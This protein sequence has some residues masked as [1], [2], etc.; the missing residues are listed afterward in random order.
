[1]PAQPPADE[2]EV[3]LYERHGPVAHVTMNRPRYRNARNSAMTYALDATFSRA[4]D[5]PETKADVLAGAGED[6]F[7]ADPVVRRGTPGVEMNIA[8]MKE[9]TG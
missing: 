5:A 2:A 4:A 8:A 3:V 9:A 6:V 1:M 7:F